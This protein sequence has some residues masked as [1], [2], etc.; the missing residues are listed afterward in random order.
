MALDPYNFA[1]PFL[2][3]VLDRQSLSQHSVPPPYSPLICRNMVQVFKKLNKH[4]A[5][6]RLT[7]RQAAYDIALA[8][9]YEAH[10]KRGTA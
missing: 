4:A 7:L 2:Q 9:V 5:D 10:L 1:T 6:R 3:G 8:R